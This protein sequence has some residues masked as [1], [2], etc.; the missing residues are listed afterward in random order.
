MGN[1]LYCSE[2][3]EGL[4]LDNLSLFMLVGTC[5][6]LQGKGKEEN[7][8]SADENRPWLLAPSDQAC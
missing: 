1:R 6:Y 2:E 4:L 3:N 8:R 7:V 5:A